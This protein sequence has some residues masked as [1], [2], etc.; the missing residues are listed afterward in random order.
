MTIKQLSIFVENRVGALLDVTSVLRENNID[1]RAFSVAETTD[2]GIVRLIVN[3]PAEARECLRASGLTVIETPVI[4][5]L[6]KDTP[7][8]FHS[9]LETLYKAEISI[10]YTYAFAKNSGTHKAYMMLRVED[11][12]RAAKVLAEAGFTLLVPGDIYEE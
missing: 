4:G 8:T 6:L 9:V 7:G 2:F 12:E 5:V 11:T 10:E 1:M 3:K